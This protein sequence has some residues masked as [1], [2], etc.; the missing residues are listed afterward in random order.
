MCAAQL[1]ADVD[2]GASAAAL[3]AVAVVVVVVVGI[4][5]VVI[6]SEFPVVVVA[7]VENQRVVSA[8]GLVVAAVDAIQGVFVY[9]V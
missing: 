4:V 3:V 8:V 7:I 9:V 1:V 6:S 5:R 2:V